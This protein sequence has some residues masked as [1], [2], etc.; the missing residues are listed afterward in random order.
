MKNYKRE[1]LKDV[2]LY[3][4]KPY[5]KNYQDHTDNV[6]HI[7]NSIKDF[8]YNKVSIT[9]DEDMVM[10]TGHGTL[11]AL[12][13]LS[14]KQ[15]PMV[16][17]IT[18]LSEKQKKAFRIADN[19]SSKKVTI[20]DEFLRLELDD[21]GVDFDMRDYGLD[22]GVSNIGE[23]APPELDSGDKKTLSQM[24]F[25]FTDVQAKDVKLAIDKANNM[26]AYQEDNPNKTGNAIHR[27][28]EFFNNEC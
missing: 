25:T 9:V 16:L 22:F 13:K 8:G 26:G 17:Q 24:A 20:N 10:L 5:D 4:I 18:G 3:H 7:K 2:P 23:I 11:A 12:E 14:Y 1:I 21:I 19:E 6:E 15:V 27:I 28:C